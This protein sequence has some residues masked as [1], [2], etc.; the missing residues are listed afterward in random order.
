MNEHTDFRLGVMYAMDPVNKAVREGHAITTLRSF[1]LHQRCNVCGH[2]FRPGDKVRIL[3]DGSVVHNFALLACAGEKTETV[4][5]PKQTSEF[6][7]GLD[8]AWP[9]PR[10]LPVI[11]LEADHPLLAPP[12]NGFRRYTCAVC[13]HTLRLHDLVIICPCH[14]EAPRCKVAIHRDPLN[15]LHCWDDWKPGEYLLHCPATTR[16]ITGKFDE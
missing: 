9:P 10:N 4:R 7:Q 1:W 5:K 3:H 13:G 11:R 12:L 6:F 2:T 16:K 14:P 15:G 8:A